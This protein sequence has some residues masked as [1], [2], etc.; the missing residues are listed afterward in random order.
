MKKNLSK[1]LMIAVCASVGIWVAACGGADPTATPEPP[2]RAT[3]TSQPAPTPTVIPPSPTP[4]P[5]ATPTPDPSFR[6][7]VDIANITDQLS[8]QYSAIGAPE[9]AAIGPN[10]SFSFEF[11]ASPGSSLSFA[12]MFVPSND[13]FFAPAQEGIPL[14]T[15][16]GP[17]EGGDLTSM[18]M[19]WDAGTEA[20]Q[21]LGAGSEQP[22][23]DPDA[24]TPDEN[25]DIRLATADNLPA[26][27]DVIRFTLTPLATIDGSTRFRAVIENVSNSQTLRLPNGSRMAVPL[28]PALWLVH[29]KTEEL[30]S[31]GQPDRGEGL[32]ILAETGNPHPLLSSLTD[33]GTRF[34]A[35]AVLGDGPAGPGEEYTLDF[36]AKPGSNLSFA[37]MLVPTNDFFFAPGEEGIALYTEQ[38]TPIS[39]GDVTSQIQIWDAGTEANQPLGEG[40]EQPLMDPNASTPDENTAVRLAEA[41]NLP[42]VSDVIN[43]SVAHM[44]D[45]LFRLT[46]RNVSNENTIQLSGGT[47]MAAPITPPLAVVHDLPGALFTVRDKDRGRGLENLAETGDTTSL[48]SYVSARTGIPTPFAPGAWITHS[49]SGLENL[50]TNDVSSN[51]LEALAEDGEPSE[52]SQFLGG[53][54]FANR[55]TAS[56]IF[57][58]PVFTL[59]GPIGDTPASAGEPGPAGPGSSYSFEIEAKP[60]DYLWFATMYVF[61]NDLIFAPS[62][63]GIPLFD[64]SGN[65]ELGQVDVMSD[66]SRIVL[67]DAGTE[68]NEAPRYGPNQ[69]HRQSGPNT[70]TPESNEVMLYLEP[71]LP[72]I[73]NSIKI[74][75]SSAE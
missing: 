26:V 19:L 68:V 30:F 37:T 57:N 63:S 49:D 18:V 60:G 8:S 16:D 46:I 56:G 41:E 29:E 27:E 58:T 62:G 34:Y 11:T 3:S 10:G 13:F 42:A 1:S 15:S 45:N 28:T 55:R 36:F 64:S 53:N 6:F 33:I 66:I 59:P 40:S 4:R 9:K 75:I 20:D 21:P 67:L 39:G 31:E 50:I 48:F 44:G 54:Q 14:F 2:P 5:T 22:L 70:G 72:D 43:V 35:S 24:S 52:F 71:H 61:S 65:P 23:M 38:G 74:T 69:A 32:E 7:K 73:S 17:I 47:G 51:G 12:T 25:I